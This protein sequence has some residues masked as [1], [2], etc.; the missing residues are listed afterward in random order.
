M[1]ENMRGKNEEKYEEKYEEL[2]NITKKTNLGEF[3]VSDICAAGQ[4]E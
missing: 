4:Q 3:Q 1:R 2:C